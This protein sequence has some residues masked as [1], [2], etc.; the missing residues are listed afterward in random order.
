MLDKTI[1]GRCAQCDGQVTLVRCRHL[2][3]SFEVRACA[4]CTVGVVTAHMVT[5]EAECAWTTS[6]P[7]E[8]VA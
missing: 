4:R 1:L 2:G 8:K 5:H 7:V 6:Q 3:C